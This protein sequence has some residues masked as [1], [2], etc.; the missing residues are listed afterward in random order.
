MTEEKIL[1]IFEENTL[2]DL[3]Y[4]L[5]KR[6]RLNITNQWLNYSFNLLQGFS[7]L[8]VAIGQAY[9]FPSL[10]WTGAG[11][12][13]L[14]TIFHVWETS[15]KK[16]QKSLYNNIKQIKLGSYIDESAVEMDDLSKQSEP[17]TPSVSVLGSQMGTLS[18][19]I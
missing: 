13:T 16:I 12:N 11:M 5:K 7:I 18:D 2:N 15:N 10:V 6:H 8:I 19:L 1:K 4:F 14:S 9:Q 17:K 3:S